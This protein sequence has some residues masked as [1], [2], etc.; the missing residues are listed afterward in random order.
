M[1]NYYIIIVL[2]NKRKIQAFL[3][4]GNSIITMGEG[5]LNLGFF[6]LKHQE[7]FVE[8]QDSWLFYYLIEYAEQ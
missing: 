5:D 4:F 8:L 6:H 2:V 7:A 3:F 1:L